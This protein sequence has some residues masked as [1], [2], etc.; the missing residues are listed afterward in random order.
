MWS[1]S[2]AAVCM[3]ILHLDCRPCISLRQSHFLFL[4]LSNNV[5]FK[6]FFLALRTV[7]FARREI[8]A[9]LA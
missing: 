1:T 7:A 2:F 3:A 5:G 8:A 6:L 4:L 9:L